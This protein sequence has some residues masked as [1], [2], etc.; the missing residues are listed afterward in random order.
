MGPLTWLMGTVTKILDCGHSYM[1]QGPNGR[2]YSRNRARLKPICYDGMSFQDHPVK[3]KGK[4]PEIIS[5][6]DPQA[7]KGENH[8]H[9]DGH[10]Q[11]G[12]QIHDI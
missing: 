2:I 10:Q 11:H 6:H 8:V 5:F 4:K 7:K 12:Y 1:I 3:K 9:P